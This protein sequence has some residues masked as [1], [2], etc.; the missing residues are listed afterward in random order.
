MLLQLKNSLINY[1]QNY[2]MDN[3]T[4]NEKR[5]KINSISKKYSNFA[6]TAFFLSY[7]FLCKRQ[8]RTEGLKKCDLKHLIANFKLYLFLLLSLMQLCQENM[9]TVES[10][11]HVS[12]SNI[13]HHG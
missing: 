2:F 8:L 3:W 13:V 12:K 1:F 7:L 4:L 10:H 5:V 6:S 9:C 11:F